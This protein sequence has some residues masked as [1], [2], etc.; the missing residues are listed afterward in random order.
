[1]K[2]LKNVHHFVN[3]DHREK[4]EITD[5]PKFGYLVFHMLTEMEYQGWPL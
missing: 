5:P 2:K 4:F 3:I 1:M